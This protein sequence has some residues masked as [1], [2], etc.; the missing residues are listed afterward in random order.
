MLA[1]LYSKPA[2]S[3]SVVQMVAIFIFE[4]IELI[5]LDTALED[6][7]RVCEFEAVNVPCLP[8]H[9]TDFER[10]LLF[11]ML[12]TLSVWIH[13]CVAS[14]LLTPEQVMIDSLYW[15]QD[16][17]PMPQIITGISVL[18]DDKSLCSNYC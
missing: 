5:F 3:R 2:H 10:S 14:A 6:C 1:Y 13:A 4:T 16:A 8:S 15:N 18:D 11:L 12:Y 17:F 7:L 9:L